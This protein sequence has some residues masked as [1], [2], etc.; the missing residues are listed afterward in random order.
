MRPVAR[1]VPP[2]HA[3]VLAKL[4]LQVRRRLEGLLAGGIRTATL[5]QGTEFYQVRPYEP[6][7]DVRGIEWNVTARTGTPHVRMLVAER[8]V[9]VLVLLDRSASMDF[10]TADRRKSELAEGVVLAFAHLTTKRGNQ[11]V[12]R[13]FG[14]SH[15]TLISPRA[16]RVGL[17]GA[18]ERLREEPADA[19]PAPAPGPGSLDEALRIAPSL[20]RHRGVVLVV[21]DL[22]GPVDWDRSLARCAR[23]HEVIVVEA[24]DPREERLPD[25]GGVWFADPE[26]GATTFADTGDPRL[27]E[28]FERA[29]A[30]ERATVR[31]AVLRTGARHI[32]LSTRGDWLHELAD[33]LSR[34]RTRSA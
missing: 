3:P 7:D 21:S 31:R 11:L 19:D 6:G 15:P 22:Q 4:E 20:L 13:T 10:G 18:L 9:T 25:L 23:R 26:T 16:S 1:P 30:E 5:G 34:G 29:A 33:R 24:R 32:P 2:V 17:L 28:R 14:G 8:A 27:R 12:L